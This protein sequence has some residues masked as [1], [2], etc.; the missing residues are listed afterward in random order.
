[1]HLYV[2]MYLIALTLPILDTGGPLGVGVDLSV[3]SVVVVADGV[4]A[5]DSLT[6][7]VVKCISNSRFVYFVCT[8]NICK[9]TVCVD[10]SDGS[11]V[12]C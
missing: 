11:C 7:V 8:Y 3:F 12:D 10:R 2:Y 1:M 9:H 6:P 5:G 4:F